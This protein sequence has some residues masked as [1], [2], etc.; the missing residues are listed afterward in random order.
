METQTN[1]KIE[2]QIPT[3]PKTH[4]NYKLLIILGAI[5]ILAILLVLYFMKE[6][7]TGTGIVEIPAEEIANI[8]EEANKKTLEIGTP[9]DEELVN[10]INY[11]LEAN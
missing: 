2:E 3:P 1:Q 4:K 8:M 7:D 10:I 11:N 6:G 9:T 5:I